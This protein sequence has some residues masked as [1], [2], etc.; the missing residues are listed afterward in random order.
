MTKPGNIFELK[1]LRTNS[2]LIF[3]ILTSIAGCQPLKN[4]SSNDYLI[5]NLQKTDFAKLNG[6]YKNSQDTVF[7]EIVHMPYRGIDENHRNLLDRLFIFIP[8]KSYEKDVTVKIEFISKRQANVSAFH[9]EQIFLSKKIRGKFKNGY[10]YL[11]P[12]V[13]LIPFFPILYVH[14]FERVRIGKVENDIAV[15]HTIKMWGLAF[16]AGGSDSG[17]STSIYKIEKE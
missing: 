12:K 1:E 6:I 14:N 13:L 4:M 16:S 2:L 8:D 17:H 11:K 10:F 15:D 3:L 9:N 7:G 5:D